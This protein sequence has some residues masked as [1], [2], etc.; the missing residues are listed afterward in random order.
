[1]DLFAVVTAKQK[2]PSKDMKQTLSP[3]LRTNLKRLFQGFAEHCEISPHLSGH[4]EQPIYYHGFKFGSPVFTLNGEA[5][6]NWPQRHIGIIGHNRAG[7]DVATDVV[8][9]LIELSTL[10][11]EL[12]LGQSLRLLPASDPVTLELGDD[13]PDL[14]DW[15]VLRHVTD[16]FRDS[17]KDGLIEIHSHAG[18]EFVISGS[19]DAALYQ[20]LASNATAQRDLP[21]LPIIANLRVAKHERWHLHL[22]VPQSWS[23]S[24]SVLAVSRFLGRL[25]EASAHLACPETLTLAR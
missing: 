24:G 22:S 8:L 10:R 11:P 12:A 23:H 20:S 6:E 9:Q 1:M 19:A 18:D 14:S 7:S 15:N 17:A 5:V 3:Q 21:S 4:I 25:L 16:E 13:A 2:Q